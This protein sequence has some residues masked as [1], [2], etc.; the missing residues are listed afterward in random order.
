MS[1]Y[2]IAGVVVAALSLA[3]P[4]FANEIEDNCTA[5]RAGA[6]LDTEGCSCVGDLTDA[7]PGLADELDG[8]KTQD[9]FEALDQS[10][11]DQVLV[12]FPDD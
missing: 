10:I 5:A 8:I 12:C 4:A 7:D 11:I 1:K 3:T 9:E 2:V 6:G